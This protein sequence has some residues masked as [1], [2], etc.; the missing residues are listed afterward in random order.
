MEQGGTSLLRDTV[1][2]ESQLVGYPTQ[3]P[4]VSMMNWTTGQP[5]ARFWCLKLLKEHFGKGDRMVHTASGSTAVVAQAFSTAKGK[6]LLL[7]NKR[8][9]KQQLQLPDEADRAE[10]SLVDGGRGL[11]SDRL[12]GKTIVLNPFEVAVVQLKD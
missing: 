12:K 9:Q 1:V 2:G 6:K 4:D 5:N 10:V 8:N 11:V 3:F 7:I